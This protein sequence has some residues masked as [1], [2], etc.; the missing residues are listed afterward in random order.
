MK[1]TKESK[2]TKK[3]IIKRKVKFEDY[4]NCSYR[5]YEAAHIENKIKHLEKKKINA[6]SPKQFTKKEWT[7]IKNT[8]KI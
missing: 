7:N 4:K 2:G 8:T 5:K 6:D 3:C 1:K